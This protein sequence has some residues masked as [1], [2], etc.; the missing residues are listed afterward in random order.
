MPGALEAAGLGA[1]V[2][3]ALKILGPSADYLGQR[4]ADAVKASDNF[5]RVLMRAKDKIGEDLEDASQRVSPRIA[6]RVLDEAP[7]M[8]SEIGAE[9]L[10]GVLAGSRGEA[11]DDRALFYLD[12]VQ[13]LSALTLRYHWCIYRALYEHLA[14]FPDSDVGHLVIAVDQDDFY[15]QGI[16]SVG[17]TVR[18]DAT[19]SL[20]NQAPDWAADLGGAVA[21][22]REVLQH[23]QLVLKQGY[24]L[25]NDLGDAHDRGRSGLEWLFSPTIFGREFFAHACGYASKER[26][27]RDLG[28]LAHVE[29]LPAVPEIRVGEWRDIVQVDG[30][31]DVGIHGPLHPELVLVGRSIDEG[32]SG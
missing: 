8:D 4:L 19:A 20:E 26:L 2:T 10:S 7:F 25:S 29:G 22:A 13:R 18:A 23:Q 17:V 3:L 32:T 24:V 1:G 16:R 28:A 30:R 14:R 12:L 9:Y 31:A 11:T 21:H 5:L 15:L 6:R 27:E